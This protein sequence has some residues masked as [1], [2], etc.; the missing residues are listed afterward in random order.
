ME[1]KSLTLRECLIGDRT[2]YR[3]VAVVVLPIIVQNTLSNVVSLLDNVMVGQV[4]TL[5]M[6]AVAI[7]N[8]LLFVFNLCIWGALAGAGIFGAQYYGQG[9]ME[10]VRQTLRMKLLIAVGLLVIAFGVLL[11]AGRPL[12]ELYI[13]ADTTAADAYAS[14]LRESGQTT[15]PMRASM[16]AMG[17]N[18]VFNSLLIFGLFGFPALGV[19]GAGIAT[20]LSRFVEFVIVVSGAHRSA[21]RYP[22]MEGVFRNF[23]IDGNLARQVAIKGFHLLLNE[24]L[25]SMSQAMLLQCYSVR[26]IQAIAAMN[27]TSTITQIFNEV[28]LSLGNATAILVG[29]ELGASRMTGARRTAWRMITLSV[30]S[31]AVM[32]TLL[33]LFSPLIPHIY[34]TEPAIRELASS[35][36]RTAALCMPLFAFANAA[37]FTLRSGGK[38]LIT[39]FFDSCYTWLIN[40][41]I[42]F[43]LSRY[44]ALPLPIVYLFVNGVDLLKCIIGFILVKKGVWVNNIVASSQD[45]PQAD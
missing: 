36:I 37:Y 33:A 11:G 3:H 32:G 43:V 6:S 2:F 7:I 42:A 18:F 4:G 16:I 17:I 1:Q 38:T 34:N 12:I 45:V 5:P 29:Q 23:H 19:V 10:G 41:P 44:T 24:C 9:N 39:F 28:F 20:S 14:T 26:G 40:F 15:L 22:F 21:E 25:W 30:S 31:C 27:I 35:V 8:Q 13:S